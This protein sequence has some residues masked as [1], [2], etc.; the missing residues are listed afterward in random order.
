[1]EFTSIP[2]VKELAGI[3]QSV[4]QVNLPGGERGKSNT[5]IC[6]SMTVTFVETTD[7][8]FVK[9]VSWLQTSS[10]DLATAKLY[11]QNQ[12]EKDVLCVSMEGMEIT[13]VCSVSLG[14]SALIGTTGNM[15]F[16]VVFRVGRTNYTVL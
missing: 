9:F 13:Q 14:N 3:S 4:R 7:L 10:G 1:L 8:N 11:I 12:S 6:D 2:G 16:D 15:E 5:M